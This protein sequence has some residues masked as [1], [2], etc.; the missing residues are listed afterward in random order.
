MQFQ[1]TINLSALAI[2]F[3]GTLLGITG[4]PGDPPLTVIQLLWINLIMDTFAVIALCLE[5]P[6]PDQMKHPP[7]G[8]TAPFI[9]RMMWTNIGLMS[10]FFTVAIL[11]LTAWLRGDGDFSLTDSATVFATYV[12]LQVFN[13][14]NARSLNPARSPLRGL[15]RNR[16]FWAIMIVIIVGQVI[17]TQIG[18]PIGANVF[19]TAPLSLGTWVLIILGSSTA[20]IFG[21]LTRIL[22]TRI[23]RLETPQ[24]ITV[25]S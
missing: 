14:I 23:G 5:P 6:T 4:E 20:L 8:R 18:G 25:A 11:A 7:K 3:F 2:V 24:P 19:R 16:A 22:R 9:T 13:E 15:F 10:A 21:E 12:F 17:M 1:L